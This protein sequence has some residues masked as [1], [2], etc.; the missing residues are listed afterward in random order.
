M[1]NHNWNTEDIIEHFTLLPPEIS[2]LGS[3]DPHNHLGK[4][5][6]LKFFQKEGRFPEDATE[7]P[8]E[9]V[10]YVAQQLDLP[11]EV[12]HNYDWDGRRLREH[13][14]DIRE[15]LGFHPATLADQDGLRTWLMNEV[16]PHEHRPTYLEQL[17]YQRLR[18]SQLEPPSKKQI[19]RLIKSALHRHEQAFFAQTAARLPEKVRARLRQL[20]Y[21]K[22]DLATDVDLGEHED[23]G[24]D[25]HRYPLHDL[26]TGAGEAKVNNIKRVANRLKL[27]QEIG[28]PLDLFAG[29]PLRFLRQYQQQTAVESISHL[30]RREKE[31]EGKPQTYTM[32]L[33]HMTVDTFGA[34]DFA[35]VS[36]RL[37]KPF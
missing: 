17:V 6:L 31:Q 25:P 28:L 27:L 37:S 29:I 34:L 15:L 19:D 26:K 23:D 2:F 14:R 11:P 3:N 21:K 10:A 30:Q 36:K 32:I 35:R 4:A 1:M 5:L 7:F 18:R 24:D 33:G 9:I 20:I 13:R 16:L 12:I 8:S 22:E